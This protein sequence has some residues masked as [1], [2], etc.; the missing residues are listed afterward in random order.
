[1]HLPP[2]IKMHRIQASC[3]RPQG[4]HEAPTT[5]HTPSFPLSSL[6]AEPNVWYG[7]VS[8]SP[9]ASDLLGS[10]GSWF[11]TGPGVRPQWLNTF[12]YLSRGGWWEAG[13]PWLHLAPKQPAFS[14]LCFWLKSS[15]SILLLLTAPPLLFK[16]LGETSQHRTTEARGSSRLLPQKPRLQNGWLG[17]VC[18]SRNQKIP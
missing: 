1:M 11:S 8:S 4:L 14:T 13:L 10:G 5:S 15:S 16:G 17:A 6:S 12:W 9:C 2:S 3:L 7:A 18:F